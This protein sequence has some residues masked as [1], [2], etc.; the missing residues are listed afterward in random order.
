[1]CV[2]VH[3]PHISE[4]SHVLGQPLSLHHIP[5]APTQPLCGCFHLLGQPL[6]HFSRLQGGNRMVRAAQLTFKAL[7]LLL[8]WAKLD[9]FN[10]Q[11]P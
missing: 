10:N 8:L 11:D 3:S 6:A 1:M 9:I 2:R 5:A 7:N 4:S